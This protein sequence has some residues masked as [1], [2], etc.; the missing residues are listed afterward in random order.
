MIF[1]QTT[2]NGH[3]V[4]V[5]D[6][7]VIAPGAPVVFILHGLGTTADDL[8]PLVTDLDLPQCRFVL[9]DA[10]LL[11]PGYPQGAY[12]WYDFQT[13]E[14]QGFQTSR[15][16]LFKL[17]DRFANDPNLRPKAGEE[18]KTA[19]VYLMGFSQGGVLSLEAGLLWKGGVRG[20]CSMSGYMPN[21][22]DVLQKAEAPFE[23]PILLVHGTEDS[24]VPVAG[25][26]KAMEALTT[27][28]Y[29]PDLQT[30]DMDHTITEDSLGAVREF[31]VK[32]LPSSGT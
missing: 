15:E 27:A 8:S 28:G 5:A 3:R 21:E 17:M 2:L 4:L 20:I 30:F 19:P 14:P 1:S 10:P 29:H 18:K 32:H 23:T 6:P 7:P 13:N 31:L 9:P 24:V 26:E 25:S 12:A 22:W 16:H 11:L